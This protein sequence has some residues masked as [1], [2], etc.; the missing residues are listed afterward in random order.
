[1]LTN[2]KLVVFDLD[3]TLANIGEAVADST[4]QSLNRFVDRNI[5]I[6]VCSGKPVSYLSGL[7]RQAELNKCIIMGENGAVVQF[8]NHLPPE[9]FYTLEYPN[10]IKTQ[11]QELKHF[12]EKDFFNELWFQPNQVGL[13]PF[14]SSE[15]QRDKIR[16]FLKTHSNLLHGLKVF[17]NSDSFDIIPENIDKGIS[18]LTLAKKLGM[19]TN[20]IIAVGNGQNDLPLF[21]VA[22]YS[23]GIGCGYLKGANIMFSSIED[24]LK[25]LLKEVN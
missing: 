12:L 24:C 9:I 5:L 22:G 18:L 2:I 13:T 23:V 1:M 8:G 3:D 4:L 21:D 6:A 25:H 16:F 7:L 17:E 15:E 11:L 10:T 14:Y 19:S 20:Q